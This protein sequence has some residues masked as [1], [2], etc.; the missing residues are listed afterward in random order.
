MRVVGGGLGSAPAQARSLHRE[1]SPDTLAKIQVGLDELDAG[2]GIKVDDHFWE[3]MRRQVRE[4]KA[5]A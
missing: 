3:E 2:L 4:P 5:G 1:L